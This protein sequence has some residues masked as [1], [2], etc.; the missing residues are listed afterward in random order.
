M[1]LINTKWI[2]LPILISI[3]GILL[4]YIPRQKERC[5]TTLLATAITNSVVSTIIFVALLTSPPSSLT[6]WAKNGLGLILQIDSISLILM[7]MVSILG[8]AI[9]LFSK[10][11]MDGDSRKVYFLRQLSITYVYALVLVTA[12]S[13][14]TVFLAWVAG[15]LALNKLL[16]FYKNRP[17]ALVPARKKFILGRIGDLFLLIGFGQI[18][19]AFGTGNVLDI[20]RILMSHP[21]LAH[22]IYVPAILLALAAILKSAQFPFHGWLIEVMET[23][24]PVSALLHAGILNG[25]PFLILRFSGLFSYANT[26]SILLITVGGLT[27]VYASLV[28]LTQPAIK[29]LLGY[30]SAAHMGFTIFLCGIGAYSAAFLHLVGHSFYKAYSFLASGNTIQDTNQVGSVVELAKQSSK[31]RALVA[32]LLAITLYSGIA[33]VIG[34]PLFK[35]EFALVGGVIILGITLLFSPVLGGKRLAK[36]LLG[37]SLM[38]TVVYLLFFGLEHMMSVLY[39]S[40]FGTFPAISVSTLYTYAIILTFYVMAIW[41]QS[42]GFRPQRGALSHRFYIHLRNG[43]YANTLFDRSIGTLKLLSKEGK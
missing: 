6:V 39:Q 13:I 41:L 43:F 1:E 5:V 37:T 30:S 36:K 11:Y 33:S 40:A 25:G 18:Y 22:S 21:E 14:V 7:T 29:T 38:A 28:L 35:K 2:V 23:P 3:V 31:L 19:Y 15:S 26:A 27:A 4:S 10:N 17:R 24:T 8:M 16:L 9:L 12:G 34:I 32:F 42:S 20:H